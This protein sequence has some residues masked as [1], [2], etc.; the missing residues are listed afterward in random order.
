MFPSTCGCSVSLAPQLQRVKH[1]DQLNTERTTLQNGIYTHL[2]SDR[3]G[4]HTDMKIG[5]PS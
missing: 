5:K 2:L 4:E 3:Q 1:R